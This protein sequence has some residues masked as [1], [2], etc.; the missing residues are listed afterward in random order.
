MRAETRLKVLIVDD[1]RAARKRLEDLLAREEDVDVVGHATSGRKAIEAISRLA[2]DL[3]FLD[4]QMPGL[5]GLEVVR[6]VGPEHM[7]AVVFVTAYDQYAVEAFEVAA[8][9]YLLKPFDDERFKQALS[10]A[11]A[12]LAARL[13]GNLQRRFAMLLGGPSSFPPSAEPVPRYLERI[14]VDMRGQMRIVPVDRIDFITADGSYAELHVG[15]DR[16]VVREQMQALEERLDPKRF[17]RIH[18]G[19]IVQLDR[20]ESLTYSPG[21]DYGV[22]LR[23]RRHLRVSRGRYEELQQRLG[24]DAPRAG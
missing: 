9:D 11:R 5:T 16:L 2:P 13:L 15:D 17:C 24:L 10:R 21:G 7:P 12:L 14:G 23:D 22:L 3:V 4:V 6:E 20:V 1:E 19:T 8:L 18:R